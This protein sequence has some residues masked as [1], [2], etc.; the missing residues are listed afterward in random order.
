MYSQKINISE[1]NLILP[2][3]VLS[4][5]KTPVESTQIFAALVIFA[6]SHNTVI[7]LL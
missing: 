1:S 4:G 5:I 7:I 6:T 2:L 3:S